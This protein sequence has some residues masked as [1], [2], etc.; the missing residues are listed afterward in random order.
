MLALTC[1]F[2][3]AK[4]STFPYALLCVCVLN[5]CQTLS[6]LEVIDVVFAGI[7][8]GT[9]YMGGHLMAQD[10]LRPGDLMSFMVA[11]Q[12]I[13]RFVIVLFLFELRT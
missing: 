8:L 1:Y 13:Q 11:S 12:T 5:F 2:I 9:L 7:V 3:A 6:C 10:K 4:F